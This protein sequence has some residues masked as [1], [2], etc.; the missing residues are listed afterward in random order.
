MGKYEKVQVTLSEPCV[1]VRIQGAYSDQDV[2]NIH[3]R[4]DD[5]G[6]SGALGDWMKSE[7]IEFLPG[8]NGPSDASLFRVNA[9]DAIRVREWLSEQGVVLA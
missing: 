5:K 7:G 3:Q 4:A 6:L 9:E 8:Y 1:V 2:L